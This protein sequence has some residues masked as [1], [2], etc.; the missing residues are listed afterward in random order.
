VKRS[1]GEFE[2]IDRLCRGLP[3]SRATIL[4][5]GDD[6]AILAG[7]RG[8]QLFTIDSQVEGVH[9]K[10]KWAAPDVWGERAL[11]V[12]LS[13]IAAMGGKP[14][15]CVVNLGLPHGL[16]P[17]VVAGLYKG[18]RKLAA[19]NRVD[20]VGGNITRATDLTITIALLG[21][22]PKTPL[23]RDA[24]RVGDQI[25]VTGT[26]G[27]AALGWRILD[28][29][30]TASGASRRFLV[31]RFLK[32]GARLRAGQILTSARPA[33]AAIDISDGLAQDLGH[34]LRRS[35]VGAEIDTKLL[36]LSEAYK[37]IVGA[38]LE[39]ALGGGDDYELLFCLNSRYD[40]Q[41]LFP[42]MKIPVT[43]IGQI[44][45]RP[46]LR[47]SGLTTP[48]ARRARLSYSGFDQLRARIR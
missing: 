17:S 5:P 28:G 39:F 6:C 9:F 22:S 3:Q 18:L 23:R 36:P 35:G 37:R 12:N 45:T 27:D 8:A 11:A 34:I 13:D 16:A 38:N 2:L 19:G 24:A 44:V 46:G 43:R 21:D 26:I 15:A 31:N 42:L 29:L 33:P 48:K 14:T 7:D 30:V 40:P 32:P 1:I 41:K 10:L 20:I 4:G 25:F 47:I